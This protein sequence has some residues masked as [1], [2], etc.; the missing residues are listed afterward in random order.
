MGRQF[1]LRLSR[2]HCQLS[3]PRDSLWDQRGEA[4]ESQTGARCSGSPLCS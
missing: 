4:Q 2:P 3:L 1:R